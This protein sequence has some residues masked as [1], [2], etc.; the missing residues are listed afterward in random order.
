MQKVV[1]KYLDARPERLDQPAAVLVAS[2]LVEAFH[3]S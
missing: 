1:M 2:A 3:C